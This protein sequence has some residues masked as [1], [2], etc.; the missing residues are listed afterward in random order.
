MMKKNKHGRII[1]Q[2]CEICAGIGIRTKLTDHE[3]EEFGH[4]C[5]ECVDHLR[6]MLSRVQERLD[7]KA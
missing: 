6:D 2:Y 4:E 7:Q 3:K 5:Q 1:L